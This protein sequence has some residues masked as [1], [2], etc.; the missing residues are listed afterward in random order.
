MP[1]KVKEIDR[2]L[3]ISRQRKLS[4]PIEFSKKLALQSQFTFTSIII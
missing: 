3:S 2:H 1:T 4:V